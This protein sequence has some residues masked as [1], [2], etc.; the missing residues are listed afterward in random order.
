[1]I[2]TLASKSVREGRPWSRLPQMSERWQSYIKGTSDFFSLNYYTSRYIEFA[3]KP[4]DHIPSWLN[5]SNLNYTFSP[6]WPVAK[7]KWLFSV[8]EG[9]RGILKYVEYLLLIYK[10]L[11]NYS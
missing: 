7:S 3:T 11:V 10:L 4:A 6:L 9:L 8:P 5:D 1:M 2:E